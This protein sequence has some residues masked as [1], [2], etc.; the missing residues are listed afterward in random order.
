MTDPI[1]LRVIEKLATS[2]HIL[3]PL[4]DLYES[5]VSE[6]LMSW[7]DLDMFTLLLTSD[8]QFEVVEDLGDLKILS[9][10][11]QTQLDL[12]GFWN[13]PLVMLHSRA[14]DLHALIQDVLYHLHEMNVALETAW[15]LRPA[16]DPEVEAELISML[17][18]GDMLEREIK[19]ALH[20]YGSSE[21]AATQ[22]TRNL[23]DA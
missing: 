7:T 3:V 21:E 11:L 2:E 19:V 10:V 12:Q 22:Q 6:G 4:Q 23:G 20:L 16:D 13:D 17:I 5:L 14:L 9:Q 8:P 1:T 15:Q 18:V